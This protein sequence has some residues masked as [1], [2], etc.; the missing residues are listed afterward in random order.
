MAEKTRCRFMAPVF[1]FQETGTGLSDT[2][3][4]LGYW[5]VFSN[6]GLRTPA[7]SATGTVFQPERSFQISVCSLDIVLY[8]QSWLAEPPLFPQ[9]APVFSTGG[10]ERDA[11]IYMFRIWKRIVLQ[12][13]EQ[14]VDAAC[15]HLNR[16]D[17]KNEPHQPCYN[18]KAALPELGDNRR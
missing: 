15:D 13:R 4:I 17:G 14:P 10:P 16:H 7:V 2:R 1:S 8:F 3:M 5:V 9:P 11:D 12:L 18:V 6:F